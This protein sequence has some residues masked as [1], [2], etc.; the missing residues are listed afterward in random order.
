MKKDFELPSGQILFH[1]DVGL[2][3]IYYTGLNEILKDLRR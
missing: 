1:G 3:N 2:S